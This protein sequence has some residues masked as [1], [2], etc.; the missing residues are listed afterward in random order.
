MVDSVV[1]GGSPGQIA[2]GPDDVAYLA[3]GGFTGDGY[4]FSYD[5]SDGT[6]LHGN[7]N[8]LAVDQNCLSVAADLNGTLFAASFTNF[9]TR[10]NSAGSELKRY[11]V[12]NGPYHVAVDIRPGDANGD[13]EVDL[14]DLLYM[15]NYLF[16]GGEPPVWPHWQGNVNGDYDQDLSDLIY[17]VSYLFMSGTRPTPGPT[18]HF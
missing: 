10:I 4:V 18:W 12:G 14:S 6:V 16:Q 17:L 5:A 13:F 2:I 7:G 15:V 9:V 8:P 11:A 1:L 3:A